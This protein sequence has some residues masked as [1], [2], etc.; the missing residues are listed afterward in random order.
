MRGLWTSVH[1]VDQGGPLPRSHAQHAVPWPPR[2]AAFPGRGLLSPGEALTSVWWRAAD[3]L[4]LRSVR[5]AA[6]G[7]PPWRRPGS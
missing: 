7:M 3:A 1:Q 5:F 2:I 4:P 6:P